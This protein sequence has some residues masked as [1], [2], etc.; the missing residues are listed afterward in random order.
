MIAGLGGTVVGAGIGLVSDRLATGDRR[1][2]RRSDAVDKLIDAY[3]LYADKCLAAIRENREYSNEL[4]V[5]QII[6][7]VGSVR[8]FRP[9]K[10]FVTAI[11]EGVQLTN[12]A[13]S[14]YAL[15][16]ISGAVIGE[17]T[18]W[19]SSGRF[20]SWRQWRGRTALL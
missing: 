13:S 7:Y 4:E 2:E 1:R 5:M 6:R 14:E 20:R 10:G 8:Q 12:R 15:S 18:V 19:A 11:L 9:P 17:L 16:Q 3:I